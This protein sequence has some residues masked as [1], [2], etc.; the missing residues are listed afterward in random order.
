MLASRSPDRARR[1]AAGQTV[2][3]NR[4]RSAAAGRH[5]G[6]GHLEGT[7]AVAVSPSPSVTVNVA[8]ASA[9]GLDV[10]ASAVNEY[11]PSAF[12]L[13][14]AGAD[15]DHLRIAVAAKH[16]RRAVDVRHRRA[17][18]T[19]TK[20]SVPV[21][22]APSATFCEASAR[23]RRRVVVEGDRQRAGGSRAVRIGDRVGQARGRIGRFSSFGPPACRTLSTSVTL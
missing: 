12:T 21:T 15:V 16:Q 9:T 2:I 14:S 6:V 10:T 13:I 19:R 8:V 20:S 23:R 3:V 1:V 17:V 5:V 4:S 11:D 18:R 22:V 7:V